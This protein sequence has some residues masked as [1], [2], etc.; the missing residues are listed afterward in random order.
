[1][2]RISTYFDEGIG[3]CGLNNQKKK[4]RTYFDDVIEDVERDSSEEVESPSSM[5]ICVMCI[6]EIIHIY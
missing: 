1:M 5:Y 4:N 3:E 2:N 6:I